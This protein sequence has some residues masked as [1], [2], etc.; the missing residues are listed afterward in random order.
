MSRRAAKGR[1]QAKTNKNEL[2][3]VA[4]DE[5]DEF[6]ADEEDEV[7]RC[8][9]GNDELN[10]DTVNDELLGLLKSEYGIKLDVGLFIQCDKC[11]VWQHGYC[12]GLFIDEDVP[13]KYWCEQ[14]KPE[15]HITVN[16]M[17]GAA[18]TRTLY[19]PV[20]DKRKRLLL[21]TPTGKNTRSKPQATSHSNSSSES[22]TLD[23]RSSRKE[24]SRG[25]DPYDEQLQKA[26]RES[27]RESGL[28]VDSGDDKEAHT[29]RRLRLEP[30]SSKRLRP[31]SAADQTYEGETTAGSKK[32]PKVTRAKPKPQAKAV[33]EKVTNQDE[34]SREELVKQ[35]SKP[36][37]VNQRS[38]IYELRKRTGAI[39][40]WLARSQQEY[41][42]ERNNKQILFDYK[43]NSGLAVESKKVLQSFDENLHSMESLTQGILSWEQ[44]FG[45][46]A[47]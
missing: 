44:K 31:D 37:F 38:S 7:T 36:R 23:S 13:D 41:E 20:N 16:E 19:K 45:K 9:C 2:E 26:L 35:P 24:R 12:V 28:A 6:N 42:E 39:L 17:S 1:S 18:E 46:Y 10:P 3:E 47:P 21:E 11:S 34:V 4:E 43:E 25:F 15:L 22:P 14:C 32:R 40:E 5:N 33:K 27:A 29:R 30:E 8:V